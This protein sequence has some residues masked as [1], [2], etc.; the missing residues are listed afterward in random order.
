MPR[1]VKHRR[2]CELPDVNLFGALNRPV[3]MEDAIVMSIEEFETIRLMDHEGL[4]QEECATR[5]NVARTTVQRI[6]VD[7][8]KK[9]ADALVHG[10]VL[11]IEGGN[12]ELCDPDTCNTGCGRCRRRRHQRR[13]DVE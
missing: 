7:A 12:Y 11:K 6:Y 8:R 9:V 2:V 10:R 3:H 1:P 13:G 4:M 5:M